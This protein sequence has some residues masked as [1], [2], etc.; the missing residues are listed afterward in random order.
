MID[1]KLHL[2]SGRNG[3][4]VALVVGRLIGM[5]PY[6]IFSVAPVAEGDKDDLALES[7]GLVDS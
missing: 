6:L 4:P 1:G 5:A 7:L 3:K 2:V